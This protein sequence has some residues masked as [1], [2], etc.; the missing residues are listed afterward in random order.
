[1]GN[2]NADAKYDYN[3]CD[4]LEHN[5]FPARL[6]SVTNGPY[7]Q[8]K[9]FRQDVEYRLASEDFQQRNSCCCIA[10]TL[11]LFLLRNHAFRFTPGVTYPLRTHR[12]PAS[13]TRKA[14]SFFALVMTSREQPASLF[15]AAEDQN[16]LLTR[17][18]RAERSGPSLEEAQTALGAM[19]GS[20]MWV[21]NPRGQ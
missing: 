17:L 15:S 12:G 3:S 2:E 6:C 10:T 19:P 16:T 7:A 20:P 4:G 9:E 14:C 13:A 8:S 5:Q 18:G 11:F 1:V 21:G